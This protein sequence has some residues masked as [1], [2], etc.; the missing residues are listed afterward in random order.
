MISRKSIGSKKKGDQASEHLKV[1]VPAFQSP[2][3]PSGLGQKPYP[4]ASFEVIPFWKLSGFDWG[5][6]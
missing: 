2:K 5:G 3:P 1:Q 6:K 4:Q